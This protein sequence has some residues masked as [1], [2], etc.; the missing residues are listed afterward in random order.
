MWAELAMASWETILHRTFMMMS[1]S[2]SPE[3]YHRMTAEKILAV[4]HSTL[5]LASGRT[6]PD[7]IASALE[8]WHGPATANARRLRGA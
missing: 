3:E 2:C 4:G 5:V 7:A 6:G 1:G 8:S